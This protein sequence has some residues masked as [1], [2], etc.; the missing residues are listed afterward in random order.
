MAALRRETRIEYE[1]SARGT[2]SIFR[3]PSSLDRALSSAERLKGEGLRYQAMSRKAAVELEPALAAI[4]EDL[5][6]AIHYES[7][8]TGNAHRFCVALA[9]MARA[10]GVEFR[11]GS[12]VTAFEL[13]HGE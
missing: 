8:E 6:G 1:R 13:D 10:L 3:D 7:D 2:L 9:E 12:E 5:A 11:F 4:S